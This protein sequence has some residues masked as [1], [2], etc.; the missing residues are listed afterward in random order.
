MHCWVQVWYKFLLEPDR[1]IT[2]I[3]NNICI[4][5]GRFCAIGIVNFRCFDPLLFQR[6]VTFQCSVFDPTPASCTSIGVSVPLSTFC[7][8]NVTIEYIAKMGHPGDYFISFRYTVAWWRHQM[9]TFSML[10]ALSAGNSPVTS[11]SPVNSPHKGQ[12]HGALVFHLI[13][14]W[15]NGWVNIRKAGDLRC[16]RAHYDVIVMLQSVAYI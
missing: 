11:E 6:S 3:F 4:E 2:K 8:E 15:I 16:H 10:L 13:C 12:W 5:H 9:E 1:E 7:W 14:A